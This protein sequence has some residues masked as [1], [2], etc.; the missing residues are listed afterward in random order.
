MENMITVQPTLAWHRVLQDRRETLGLTR[1][2]ASV[3]TRLSPTTIRRAEEDPD[4]TPTRDTVAALTHMW[5]EGWQD[6]GVQIVDPEAEEAAALEHALVQLHALT[7]PSTRRKA[8]AMGHAEALT[9]ALFGQ[10]VSYLV[11]DGLLHGTERRPA[12]EDSDALSWEEERALGFPERRYGEVLQRTG[13]LLQP[14]ARAASAYA[15]IA[16]GP[17]PNPWQAAAALSV[18]WDRLDACEED[19]LADLWAAL[20]LAQAKAELRLHVLGWETL[21]ALATA[22]SLT[23]A[24]QGYLDRFGE[25]RPKLA[26]LLWTV[27][28]VEEDDAVWAHLAEQWAGAHARTTAADALCLVPAAFDPNLP[29][30]SAALPSDFVQELLGFTP[31]DAVLSEVL[32]AARQEIVARVATAAKWAVIEAGTEARG[33]QRFLRKLILVCRGGVDERGKQIRGAGLS[34]RMLAH[35]LD[36][37]AL[38]DTA[39]QQRVAEQTLW[40]AIAEWLAHPFG[41]DPSTD[42]SR[43]ALAGLSL[44]PEPPIAERLLL[45]SADAHRIV[46]ELAPRFLDVPTVDRL[47]RLTKGVIRTHQGPLPVFALEKQ[48]REEL[49]AGTRAALRGKGEESTGGKMSRALLQTLPHRVVTGIALS[50]AECQRRLTLGLPYFFPVR[51]MSQDRLAAARSV[52][53]HVLRATRQ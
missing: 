16:R 7:R 25:S 12:R 49:V 35:R 47:L 45:P 40:R 8:A 1:T 18:V 6:A 10:P 17:T 4:W 33:W 44:L 14:L 19:D 51:R 34:P 37:R 53:T 24:Q 26:G 41:P 3:L 50:D 39:R 52:V 22:R 21:G 28:D 13:G 30:A 15:S 23:E 27:L 9:L 29:W 2:W 11:L 48:R 42:A 5:G 31:D 46:A 32:T 43:L 20:T 38:F 36:V